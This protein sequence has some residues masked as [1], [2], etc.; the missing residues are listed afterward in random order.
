MEK[1]LKMWNLFCRH[2]YM[3][4][5]I[6]FFAIIGVLDENSLL[7]R[8]SHKYEIATL[9]SEIEKYKQQ[10]EEDTRRLKELDSNPETIEK[11]ARERYLMKCP[12][13]DVFIFED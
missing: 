9:E 5:T 13:E 2:K 1:L 7:R 3:V 11:I 4:V 6:A 10:Y 12:D 8:A